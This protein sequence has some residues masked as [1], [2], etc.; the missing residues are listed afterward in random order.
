LIAFWQ[1][2]V[3]VQTYLSLSGQFILEGIVL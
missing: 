3:N 2:A 1:L